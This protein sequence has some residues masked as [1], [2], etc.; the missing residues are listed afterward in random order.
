MG[1]QKE[2]A[3]KRGGG[4]SAALV[5][6]LSRRRLVL[7][8]SEGKRLRKIGGKK[9][10]G[11]QLGGDGAVEPSGALKKLWSNNLVGKMDRLGRGV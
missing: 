5:A 1:R 9:L 3:N 11:N 7:L 10:G 4:E 8:A 6:G 2:S